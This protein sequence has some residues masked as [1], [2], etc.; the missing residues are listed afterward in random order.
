MYE[1]Q[2]KKKKK[3]GTEHFNLHNNTPYLRYNLSSMRS[4]NKQ[5]KMGLLNY[6]Q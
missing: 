3:K 1:T 2:P 6:N 4:K 5:R